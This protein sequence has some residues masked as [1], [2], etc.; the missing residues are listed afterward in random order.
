MIYVGRNPEITRNQVVTVAEEP[1]T[2]RERF[3]VLRYNSS[4]ISVY[5]SD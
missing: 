2:Q 4:P 3:V 1:K 5:S